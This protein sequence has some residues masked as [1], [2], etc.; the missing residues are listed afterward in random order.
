MPGSRVTAHDR[1]KADRGVQLAEH[2]DALDPGAVGEAALDARHQRRLGACPWAAAS[3]AG[4]AMSV[5]WMRPARSRRIEHADLAHAQRTVAVV[6]DLDGLT[7]G[8][9]HAGFDA[10]RRRRDTAAGDGE[11][12]PPGGAD[13]T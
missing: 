9:G 2:L 7:V 5:N 3:K 1:A 6:E 4:A 8:Q 11:I 13:P 12:P 10:G